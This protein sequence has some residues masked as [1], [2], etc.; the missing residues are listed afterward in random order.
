MQ[1]LE[2]RG[3]LD[4]LGSRTE[5]S[6][7]LSPAPDLTMCCLARSPMRRRP[8][9]IQASIVPFPTIVIVG[10]DA[11]L[12]TLLVP[13]GDWLLAMW[14]RRRVLHSAPAGR[15]PYPY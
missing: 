6:S 14:T 10:L 8:R 4:G 11:W 5:G 9:P 13:T 3:R 12:R 15:G 7:R 2:R 1:S